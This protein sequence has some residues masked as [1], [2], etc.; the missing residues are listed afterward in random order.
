VAIDKQGRVRAWSRRGASLGDRLGSLL[1][2]LAEAPGGSVFDGELVAL[3]SQDGRAVQDFAAVCRATLQG[4]GAAASQLHVVAFDL[5]ELAGED[6]RALPWTA[7]LTRR[8]RTRGQR[9]SGRPERQGC[10]N[11]AP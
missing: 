1:K 4:D 11:P 6:I 7:L 8:Q 9:S 2:P 5:L 3:S 10:E